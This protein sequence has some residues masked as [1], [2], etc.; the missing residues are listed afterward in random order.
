MTQPGAAD[1]RVDAHLVL[2]IILLLLLRGR[3]PVLAAGLDEL[4]HATHRPLA[5]ILHHLKH[6][7]YGTLTYETVK[8][9]TV[10]NDTF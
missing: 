1:V 6:R 9:F 5:V 4:G 2:I 10:K 3:L 8:S 7:S